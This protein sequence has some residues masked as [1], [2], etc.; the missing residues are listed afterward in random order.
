[1]NNNVEILVTAIMGPNLSLLTILT[2]RIR[3]VS[4]DLRTS[5]GR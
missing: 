3:H 2:D 5:I 1:M 4:M